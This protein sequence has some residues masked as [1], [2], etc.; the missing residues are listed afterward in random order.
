MR[1]N[2]LSFF[3][4]IQPDPRMHLASQATALAG[5][6][7]GVPSTEADKAGKSSVYRWSF[8]IHKWAGLFSAVWLSVLGLTGFFLDHPDWRWQQT[9][10]PTW[11]T[12]QE[13]EKAAGRN[14]VRLMQI[15]PG[16][17]SVRVAGG[18][19]GLWFSRDAGTTWQRT[20]FSQGDR[21][22]IFAIEPDPDLG[23]KRLWFA[24]DDGVYLSE[25][26]GTNAHSATLAG[27]HITA[28]AAGASRDE[29]LAVI[30]K[31]SVYRFNT[32]APALATP[33]KLE[34][35]S[36]EAQPESVQVNRFMRAL[37][38]GEGVTDPL[39]SL[40]M[41][42]LGAIGMFVL[43]L[44]GLLYWG[45][46]KYWKSR[47][48]SRAAP[49][50]RSA[51][52]VKKTT[53]LWL[54]R[55]HSITL[56]IASVLILIYL[57]ITGIF[58]GHGKELGDWM[59]ATRI[60]QTYLPPAFGLS[61]WQGRIDAIVAQPGQPGAISIGNRLGLFSTLDGGRNWKRE[62][63][64]DGQPLASAAR[65]RRFGDTL[66]IPNG[67]A[68]P[69]VIRGADQVKHEVIVG[70][71]HSRH[72]AR[73]GRNAE[74]PRQAWT[75]SGESSG[76]ARPHRH[77]GMRQKGDQAGT[78]AGAMNGPSGMARR[79][80]ARE[81]GEGGMGGM[82]MP[83]DVTQLGDKFAWKS[84]GKLLVTDASGREIEKLDIK[85]PNDP[86]VPWFTWFLRVHMGTI[87]WSEW[88]WVNDVFAIAAVLLSVTGLIR[89]WRKKWA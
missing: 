19:R 64:A 87:F 67:M 33:F 86:G 45:L 82:F 88:R 63:G 84:A 55:T 50:S 39:T 43:S 37:H 14:V 73:S 24:T 59:R 77:G 27:Q 23:W 70:G 6:G 79:G 15:D 56:G 12:T 54:F 34:A 17:S 11:L 38:F 22:Q 35:L 47:A 36:E 13:L 10:A 58:V 25:D 78:N 30:D 80:M 41:N 74:A 62:I 16:N 76:E 29:M 46:P 1:K 85:Q 69:S 72:S 5:V 75:Q 53:V 65:L 44:T 32:T 81:A 68:G 9:K 21:P 8:V 49:L 40:I 2:I 60:P 52:A 3:R 26:A 4:W 28:L 42:D 20:G 57:S 61:S 83:S 66:L 89:W 18:Q 71:D 48:K 7:Y 31:S 51:K